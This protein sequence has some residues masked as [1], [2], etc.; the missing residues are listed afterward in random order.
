MK[1][2]KN[3]YTFDTLLNYLTDKFKTKSTGEPF[4]KSDIAQYLIRKKLPKR[5]G[6]NKL[7]KTNMEGVNIIIMGEATVKIK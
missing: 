1:L 3:E 6:G 2:N 4:N 5:Y 7:E